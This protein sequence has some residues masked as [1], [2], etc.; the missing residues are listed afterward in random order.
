VPWSRLQHW[1][2]RA[3]R[4]IRGASV[5]IFVSSF[6][7]HTKEEH[8]LEVSRPRNSLQSTMSRPSGKVQI[9]F[10][11]SVDHPMATK[12]ARRMTSTDTA[13]RIEENFRQIEEELRLMEV[14]AQLLAQQAPILSMVAKRLADLKNLHTD[15]EE[16]LETALTCPICS[17]ERLLSGHRYC[18]QCA[19][20]SDEC[21][22]CRERPS[23]ENQI[24]DD[25]DDS[26]LEGSKIF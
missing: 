23:S 4:L 11:S 1:T 15:Q 25:D 22:L 26:S 8:F 6:A 7:E 5:S 14:Q 3:L 12:Y 20:R 18:H 16:Q 19:S 10:A 17:A 13:A 2:V 21:P 9:V 24:S